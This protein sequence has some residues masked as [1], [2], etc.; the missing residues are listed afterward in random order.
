MS[1]RGSG[2]LA[3]CVAAIMLMAATGCGSSPVKA[4][5]RPQ[6]PASLVTTPRSRA[7]GKYPYPI[8]FVNDTRLTVFVRGCPECGKGHRL[9]PNATWLTGVQGG[10][11]EV[12]FDTT[13]GQ[14]VGC[15]HMINGVMPAA[16]AGPQVVTVS[17]GIPCRGA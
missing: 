17:Y 7:P 8:K 4:A 5:Q 11:T 6:T 1:A 16:G 2:S 10:A 9:T 12:V 15:I 13:H 14:R 3:G